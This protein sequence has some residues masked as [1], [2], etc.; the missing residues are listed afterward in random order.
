MALVKNYHKLLMQTL[1]LCLLSPALNGRIIKVGPARDIKGISEA[2]ALCEP[3]DT[4]LIDNGTY[5]GGIMLNRLRGNGLLPVSILAGKPGEVIIRGGESG[6]HLKDPAF[7]L[8]SGLVFEGQTG[9]GLNI[10]DDGDYS[11]PA[12][13]IEISDCRWGNLNATGNN[14]QLKMSGVDFFT[15]TDCNFSNGS[16]GGS[17][18]D[19]VGCHHGTI[20]GCT[21]SEAGMNAIQAKGGSSDLTIRRNRFTNPGE[22]AINIGG[23]TGLEFFRPKGF[24]WE[25]SGI[26]V[27]SNIF[28]GGGS[29]VAF[30]GASNCEVV[31]NTITGTT[32]WVVRIL[33][34]NRNEGMKPCSGNRFINNIVIF[35]APGRPAVNIGPGTDPLTFSFSNNLWYNPDDPGWKGPGAS[36]NETNP[37]IGKDPMLNMQSFTPGKNS[38]AKAMGLSVDQPI[39]DFYSNGFREKRSIGAVE[40]IGAK[41]SSRPPR[42]FP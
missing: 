1:I 7:I 39:T 15:I 20:S 34:E 33:Q 13:N 11:T 31:N 42:F 17:M 21:F 5:K 12:T 41:L 18:I 38:P 9:N 23:S 24:E 19:M 26:R 28:I 25:A 8:I 16:P 27:W 10:D 2:A 6:I 37:I 14:D 40:I 30:V 22:R 29:A 4:I 3:G 36:V 32:L 35:R